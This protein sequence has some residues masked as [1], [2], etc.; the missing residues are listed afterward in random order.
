MLRNIWWEHAVTLLREEKA[1][2][3]LEGKPGAMSYRLY[4][5]EKELLGVVCWF[6]QEA[7]RVQDLLDAMVSK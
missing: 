4:D 6:G 5:L 7:R 3:K 2:L 1:I